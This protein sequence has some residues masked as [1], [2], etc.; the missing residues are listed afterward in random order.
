MLSILHPV[1]KDWHHPH[2]F[3][4]LYLITRTCRM[5]TKDLNKVVKIQVGFLYLLIS[6]PWIQLS[7]GAGLEL[8]DPNSLP[9]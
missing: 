5:P 2:Q 9:G 3:S 1:V 4:A 7:V 6:H 8:E